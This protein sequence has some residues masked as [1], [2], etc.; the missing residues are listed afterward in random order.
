TRGGHG[1]WLVFAARPWPLAVG[2]GLA[3]ACARADSGTWSAERG[4][5][6]R[7][8]RSGAGATGCRWRH[9][10]GRPERHGGGRL[11]HG[12]DGDGARL[13]LRCAVEPANRHRGFAAAG[14]GWGPRGGLRAPRWGKRA[15]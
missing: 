5:P 2:A 3:G 15:G 14:G 10:H 4:P 8:T 9:L 7:S 1:D 6:T 12:G 13:R 11:A